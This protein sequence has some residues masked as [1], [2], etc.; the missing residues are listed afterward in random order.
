MKLSRWIPFALAPIAGVVILFALY[1]NRPTVGPAPARLG[2]AVLPAPDFE[3][4]QG[5]SNVPFAVPVFDQQGNPVTLPAGTLVQFQYRIQTDQDA[6][7]E[8]AGKVTGSAPG[9]ATY[10]FKASDTVTPGF[11]NARFIITLPIAD[12]GVDGS[13]QT[14]S[15]PQN[16][17]LRVRVRAAP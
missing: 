16:R 4:G 12:G 15:Y 9:L 7:V 6:G 13:Q 3:L 14:F 2:G 10:V 5:D 11:Y 8:S 17:L 1:S